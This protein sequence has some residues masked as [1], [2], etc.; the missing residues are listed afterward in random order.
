MSHS[1]GADHKQHCD[2]VKQSNYRKNKN[3]KYLNVLDHDTYQTE[4]K[5]GVFTSINIIQ[6]YMD[7]LRAE[8]I[9]K[10]YNNSILDKIHSEIEVEVLKGIDLI[11]E[12]GDF[13]GVMGKSGCG[14][15]TLLKILGTIDRPTKGN[16]FY[17]GQDLKKMK[18]DDISKLRRTQIGF[19]FQDFNLMESLTVKENIMLPM[20]LDGKKN[21][22]MQRHAE[23]RADFFE[24]SH[25]LKKYPSEISGGERQRTAIARA[26][27]NEPQIIFADEPTGNLDSVSA[28]K[29]MEC[30]KKINKELQKAIILVTHD[31]L[32]AS[33]CN[34]LIF[35]KDGSI[36]DIYEN[37]KQ[38]NFYQ[39]IMDKMRSL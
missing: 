19:V 18:D 36:V 37:R 10:I 3:L 28:L 17:N 23:Q 25:I 8:N 30:F 33:Y 13:L 6:G 5:H 7:I 22:V 12:N 34:K 31:P 16:I 20:I 32:I 4:R 27:I 35:L 24:I 21:K 26:L 9:T 2:A 38:E 39:S 14:K 29:V 1:R 15:T 11:L